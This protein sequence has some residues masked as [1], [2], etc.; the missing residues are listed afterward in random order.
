MASREGFPDPLT[1][2]DTCWN[3]RT[4]AG[5]YCEGST[6]TYVHLV[7]RLSC[8]EHTETSCHT[9]HICDMERLRLC[10]WHDV[11][12]ALLLTCVL[13]TGGWIRAP[14]GLIGTKKPRP[15]SSSPHFECQVRVGRGCC[16]PRCS[17]ISGADWP[18]MMGDNENVK[19]S[20]AITVYLH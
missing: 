3:N 15:A 8:R 1:S 9:F 12:W 6:D 16:R 10:S 5:C 2:S 4:C 20:S 18:T 19:P 13:H 17:S 11:D 14:V 7:D